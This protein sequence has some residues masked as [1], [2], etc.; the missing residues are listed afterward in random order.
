LEAAN[1]YYRWTSGLANPEYNSLSRTFIESIDYLSKLRSLL[2]FKG[3]LLSALATITLTVTVAVEGFAHSQ[4]TG[5]DLGQDQ[6]S[7]SRPAQVPSTEASQSP[8][9]SDSISA[10]AGLTIKEINFPAISAANDQKRFRQ[11]IPLQPGQPLDRDRLRESIQKLYATGR[12]ADLR[13]EAE[14]TA[15]GRV[16]VSFVTSANFFIGVVTVEGTPTHPSASQAANASKLQLGELLTPDKIERALA[17]LKQLLEENGYYR[18]SVTVA[19]KELPE[20]QQVAI[21]FRVVPGAQARVGEVILTGHPLRTQARFEDVAHL[22]PGD[23]VSV[24]LISNSLNRLRKRYQKQDR[25]LAQVAIAKRSYRSDANVIDYTFNIEPGPTVNITAEGFKISRGV[26]K[27]NVPVYEEDALDDDL[28]N[29][30]RRNLLNYLQGRGYFDAKVSLKRQANPDKNQLN[31]VYAIDPGERHKLVKILISGNMAGNKGFATELIRSRMQVQPAERFFSHGRYSQGLL[32]DDIR[33]LEDLYRS[34][35]FLDVKITSSIQDDYKGRSNEL[36]VTIKVDIGEQTLVGVL[37]MIGNNA[38]LDEPL[39]ELNTAVGQAFAQTKIAEDREIILNYY[40]NRGFPNATFDASAEPLPGVDHR[41]DVKFTI[42]EG[43]Q[44]FVDKMLVSGLHYTKMFVVQRQIQVK[45]G[46]PLSQTDM[47]NTQQGLYDLG[48][49]SQVDTA[50]QNPDGA[51]KTKNVLVQVQE[52][53]RYTFTYGGGF[54]FQTGQPSSNSAPGITG[55][56]PLVSLGVSRLN[57]RGRD[58]TIT[59][60]GRYGTL[61]KRGLLRYDAP[62]WLNNPNWILS[63]T[64][65]YDDT[66]DVTTFHSQRLEGSVQAEEKINKISTIDYRFQYRLVKATEVEI[67]TNLIPLLSLPVRVGEPGLGYIRNTR[68]SDLETTKGTYNTIDEGVAS[69]YFGSQANFNRVLVQ[70]STY[71]AF[72]KHRPNGRKFVFAR[73]IRI[74]LESPFNKTINVEPGQSAPGSDTLIPLAERFFSGGGN[75]NRGFGLNQAGPRDPQT[76]FPLGGSAM[77][78]NSF[79]LRFPPPTLPYVQDN[80]SFAIFHDSGNVFADG[81]DE[82]NSLLHWRQKNPAVCLQPATAVQCNYNYVSQAIGVGIRYKTP[83][84]P[85]RF[86]FGYNL[87]P[88]AFPGCVHDFNSHFPVPGAGGYC[89]DTNFPY[90]DA[91]H[92]SHFNVYFSIGQSF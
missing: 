57:F 83:V 65:F 81:K 74:G 79:E 26:F 4:Q 87:N 22:H 25:W 77:F 59:F 91:Q 76:G 46:D 10:Y 52:A 70:N 53:R 56:S 38:H 61:Q 13:A 69:G 27:R 5:V 60:D 9:S 85:V 88:P 28:L 18:S 75:S 51:E 16:S 41:M 62:R 39:P 33:G 64:G 73:S 14:K 78:L 15:D 35:G 45:P 48:I 86:D 30:G 55:V 54:E 34:N 67:S 11:L 71:H 20:I 72:G 21:T 8:A 68:D 82:V 58:H 17:N 37:E 1:H 2:G 42:H 36:A 29:E 31:V 43:E 92:V 80:L 49:F 7:Q 23:A 50:V 63:L 47:L 24:Q 84:G 32:N 6:S 3:L 89:P 90:F 44:E 12:F 40:Y 66:L 19:K